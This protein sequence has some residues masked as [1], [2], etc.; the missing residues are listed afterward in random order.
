LEADMRM[1]RV[2]G[3]GVCVARVVLKLAPSELLQ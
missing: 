3:W 1:T 2:S